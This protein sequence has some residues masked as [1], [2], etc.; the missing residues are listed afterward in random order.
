MEVSL[1]GQYRF[2][3]SFTANLTVTPWD[4]EH[5]VPAGDPYRAQVKGRR[6]G[7]TAGANSLVVMEDTRLA[8]ESAGME[9]VTSWLKTSMDGTNAYHVPK[10]CLTPATP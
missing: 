4:V 3:S 10:H 9:I 8:R 1:A 7:R 5:N 2:L 6:S